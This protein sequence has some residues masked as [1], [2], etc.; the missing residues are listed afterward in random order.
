MI[1]R[2]CVRPVSSPFRLYDERGRVLSG[3]VAVDHDGHLL[4]GSDSARWHA[5][6]VARK[7]RAAS[8][9]LSPEN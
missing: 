6:P 5:R 4:S 8:T 9:P 2:T 3:C 7:L 1:C